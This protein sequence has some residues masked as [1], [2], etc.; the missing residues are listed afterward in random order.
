MNYGYRYDLYAG[1]LQLYNLNN[2]CFWVTQCFGFSACA[3]CAKW[4]ANSSVKYVLMFYISTSCSVCAVPNMDVFFLI[5]AHTLHHVYSVFFF[6]QYLSRLYG[7]FNC[8]FILFLDSAF[9][10]CFCLKYFCSLIY[11]FVVPNLVLLW[12]HF[13]SVLSGPPSRTTGTCLLG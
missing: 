13:Q 4:Y 6:C 5:S 2:P 11:G 7:L 12:F 10:V 8:L 3:V 9:A 1:Y